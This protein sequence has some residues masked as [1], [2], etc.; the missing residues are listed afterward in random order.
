VTRKAGFACLGFFYGAALFVFGI[1]SAGA[2]HGS[3]LPVSLFAAPLSVIPVAGIF[4]API[5]W[6]VVWYVLGQR[7]RLPAFGLLAMH[8]LATGLLLLLGSPW[9]PGEEQWR[10][11][12]QAARLAP[13]VVWGGLVVYAAGQVAAWY[14]V[15]RATDAEGPFR[16]NIA[17]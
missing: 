10:Y 12:R 11:F 13:A 14:L 9:E 16:S 1:A 7:R 5:W 17:G 2:G 4:V 8:A 15:I 6:T 3:Y